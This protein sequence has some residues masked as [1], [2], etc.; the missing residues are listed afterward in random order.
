MNLGKYEA[1]DVLKIASTAFAVYSV[2][3]TVR[4]ARNDHDGLQLTEALLRGA[5]LSLSIILII[6]N[7]RADDEQALEGSQGMPA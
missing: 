6:R 3:K 7:L 4:D 1:Q 2:V 5:T